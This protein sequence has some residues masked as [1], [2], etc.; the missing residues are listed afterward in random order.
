MRKIYCILALALL[1]LSCGD[2]GKQPFTPSLEDKEW[3]ERYQKEDTSEVE[4]SP[5]IVPPTKM[6]DAPSSAGSPSL[7]SQHDNMHGFD[8]ASEDDMNDNGMSRYM[9]NY[10]DEGWD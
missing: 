1:M 6:V 3:E 8:P 2:K 5:D 9:E 7:S 10:D 4:E